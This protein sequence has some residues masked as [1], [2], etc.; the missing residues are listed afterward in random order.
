MISSNSSIDWSKFMSETEQNHITHTPEFREWMVGVLND[1]NKST[2]I[3]FTKKDG[4]SRTMRCTRNTALIPEEFH[5]KG[6]AG[7]IAGAIRAFDL[8]KNE[9]RSFL[10]ENVKHIDYQF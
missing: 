10:P 4:T 5:P 6:S 1:A 7:D 2:V 8:E 3:T 9:W